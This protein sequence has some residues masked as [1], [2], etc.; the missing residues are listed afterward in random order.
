M[1]VLFA[2][3][4]GFLLIRMPVGFCMLCSSMIYALV[5]DE[6]LDMLLSRAVAGS[7][8]FTLLA[9]AFFMLAGDI[10]N[11]GG[12]TTRIFNFAKK[13]VGWLPGG[14]GHG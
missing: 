10:M 13:L 5:Y 14:M 3:F 9:L 7:S 6:S 1:G 12:I 8:G 11:R 2:C 4:F